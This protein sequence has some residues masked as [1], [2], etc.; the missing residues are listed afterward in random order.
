MINHGDAHEVTR[1]IVIQRD[2]QGAFRIWTEQIHAWW[3]AGHSLSGDPQTTVLIE[4]RVGG[5]FYERTSQGI[6]YEWGR[7]LVWEPPNALAY[8][9]YLGSGQEL[10]TRVDV[11]FSDLGQGG[12][13]IDIEHR[14]PELIGELWWANK[15]Q[16]GAAWEKV[17]PAYGSFCATQNEL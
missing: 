4:G 5:R 15:A 12:T 2:I 1:S 13:R 9:W 11:R 6:E 17:L 14:G 3:P 8:T 7:I 16:Y 10:P